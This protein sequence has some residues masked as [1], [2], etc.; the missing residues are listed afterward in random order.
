MS[1]LSSTAVTRKVGRAYRVV[2][3]VRPAKGGLMAWRQVFY[4]N[5]W[6]TVQKARTSAKGHYAFRIKKARFAGTTRTFR[7][8]IVKKGVVVGVSPQFTVT[9]KR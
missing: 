9:V 5:A 3:V 6:V 2:G 7:V 4:K 8:L 1:L